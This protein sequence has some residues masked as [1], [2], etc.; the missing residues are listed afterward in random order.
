[1]ANGKLL[2]NLVFHSVCTTF[3]PYFKK[4][5]PKRYKN[6]EKS[7]CNRAVRSF[8][9]YADDSTGWAHNGLEF[10]EHIC[11]GYQ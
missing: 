8:F 2:I 3:A 9:R 6:D 1:M 7:L 5:L 10:V 11:T 4:L